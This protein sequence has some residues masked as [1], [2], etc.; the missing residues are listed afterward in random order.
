MKFPVLDFLTPAKHTPSPH[1]VIL[2]CLALSPA[3]AIPAH[4]ASGID[5]NIDAQTIASLESRVLTA[6]PREQCF[7]YTELVHKMTE[8][9][10]KQ[11]V[12]GDDVAAS[13]TLKK[14]EH[15]AQM[16]HMHLANDTK[17][18]KNA[19]MLMRHTTMRLTAFLHISSGD[20]REV[21]K[22]TLAR[23]DVVQEEL[24]TQVFQH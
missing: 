1:L 4:A 21:V 20:D 10:G 8:Q 2:L 14:I 6:N 16:I 17:R 3:L 19:E 23:L 15:Y 7:L 13:A 22:S 24:L 9:A 18:L 5:E 12:A 11:I